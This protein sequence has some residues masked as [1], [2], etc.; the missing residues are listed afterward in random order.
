MVGVLHRA[1]QDAIRDG[2]YEKKGILVDPVLQATLG[3]A[4][5]EAELYSA[6]HMLFMAMPDRLVRGSLF[7]IATQDVEDGV[8]LAWDSREEPRMSFAAGQGLL[9]PYEPGERIAIALAD[10]SRYCDSRAGYVRT[11]YEQVSNSSSFQRG[12]YLH[13]RVVARLPLSPD[14]QEVRSREAQRERAPSL[15]HVTALRAPRSEGGSPSMGLQP[16]WRVALMARR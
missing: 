2:G 12:P 1:I 4:G 3:V 9:A 16:A 7:L 8:E 14:V 15:P 13:R 10:L 5:D 11:S 6:V